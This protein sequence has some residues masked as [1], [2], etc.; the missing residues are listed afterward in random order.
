MGGADLGDSSSRPQEKPPVAGSTALELH[1]L[2]NMALE[3]L[4]EHSNGLHRS[5][6]HLCSVVPDHDHGLVG[7]IYEVQS[8][9]LKP[10]LDALPAASHG[11]QSPYPV[12]S[13]GGD[14][15]DA[16]LGPPPT[17][18]R[19]FSPQEASYRSQPTAMSQELA[20]QAKSPHQPHRRRDRSARERSKVEEVK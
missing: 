5:F 2:R 16:S 9:H 6:G 3:D 14:P 8:R 11:S 19:S 17:L 13:R 15:E 18:T 20:L 7:W 4:R 1:H 12:A 10:L